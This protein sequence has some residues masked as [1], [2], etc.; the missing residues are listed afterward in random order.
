MLDEV[1]RIGRIGGRRAR[2]CYLVPENMFTRHF[3]LI[4]AATFSDGIQVKFL[5]DEAEARAWLMEN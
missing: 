3:M 1:R 4:E 2:F 5:S